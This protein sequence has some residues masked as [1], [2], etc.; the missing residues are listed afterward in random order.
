MLKSAIRYA[1]M[2][3]AV[4]LVVGALATPAQAQNRN[5]AA[6]GTRVLPNSQSLVNPYYRVAPGLSL[7]QYAYNVRTIG[8]AYAS[9]PPWVYGYNPYPPVIYNAPAYPY[10]SNYSPYYT[11]PYTYNYNAYNPYSYSYYP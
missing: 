8:R 3:G 1:V 5:F 11:T 6:T 9:V 10:Y 4:V 7:N 2:A